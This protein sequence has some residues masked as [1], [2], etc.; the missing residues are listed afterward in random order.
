MLDAH[1]SFSATATATATATGAVVTIDRHTMIVTD[2]AAELGLHRAELWAIVHESGSAA[3]EVALSAQLHARIYP[4]MPGCVDDGVVLVIRR[5]L[6]RG[7][8]VSTPAPAP[9]LGPL[10]QAERAVIAET[11]AECGG[12]K[13]EAAIRL[14]LSRGTLYTRLRRYRLA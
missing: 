2:S 8:A 5:G 13:T 3:R 7:L 4:L 9:Q 1:L 10:E 12:N 14:G 6:P 11:L